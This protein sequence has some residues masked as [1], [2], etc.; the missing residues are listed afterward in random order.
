MDASKE[1]SRRKALIQFELALRYSNRASRRL[2]V[3]F[4]STT[5]DIPTS[6]ARKGKIPSH[7]RRYHPTN[8]Q[9]ED[10]AIVQTHFLHMMMVINSFEKVVISNSSNK[11]NQFT[12]W[13]KKRIKC[14]YHWHLFAN[15]TV[16]LSKSNCIKMKVVAMEVVC[17]I[18][19][20]KW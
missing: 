1:A 8:L 3:L 12:G 2:V 17:K 9:I 11:N 10:V 20:P 14:K 6:K 16:V 13:L 18:L 15:Q 19:L 7:Q 5:A 4:Y